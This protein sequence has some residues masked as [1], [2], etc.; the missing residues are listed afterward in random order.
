MDRTGIIVVTICA[1]LL[2]L[3]YYDSFKYES[4]LAQQR[5]AMQTNSVASAQSP[6]A[7]PAVSAPSVPGYSF[8]SNA[9]EKIITVTNVFT[10]SSGQTNSVRYT[11][12]SSGGGIESI[13]LLDF[14]ESITPRWKTNANTHAVATLNA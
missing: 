3:W 14:P 5:A 9:A 2:G 7:G 8:S 4:V 13:E 1:V 12:T 10:T 11:F 6:A